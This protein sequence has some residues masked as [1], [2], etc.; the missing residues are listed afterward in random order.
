MKFRVAFDK[1][2]QEDKLYNYYFMEME[3]PPQFTNWKAIERLAG[4]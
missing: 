2:E 3:G 1:M 4:S